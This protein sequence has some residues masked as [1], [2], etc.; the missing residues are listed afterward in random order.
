MSYLQC[1]AFVMTGFQI[2]YQS[3][4]HPLPD[5]DIAE[6]IASY[7]WA[8]RGLCL[9]S[10]N[11]KGLPI[12]TTDKRSEHGCRTRRNGQKHSHQQDNSFEDEL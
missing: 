5:A 10:K 4:E 6:H 11:S 7:T 9:R 8:L 1:S 12:R 3:L 2:G